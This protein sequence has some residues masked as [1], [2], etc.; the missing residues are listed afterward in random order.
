MSMTDRSVK[1]VID[2]R[3]RTA[4]DVELV[5]RSIA[6]MLREMKV[7]A[8]LAAEVLGVH[9]VTY[10]KMV[11]SRKSSVPKPL[12]VVFGSGQWTPDAEDQDQK[13]CNRCGGDN[14]CIRKGS[15]LYCAA[16]HKTGFE[17]QIEA[18]RITDIFDEAYAT[19]CDAMNKKAMAKRRKKSRR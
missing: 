4:I 6:A 8:R 11:A 3:K 18:E 12:A 17:T 1:V 15:R 19:E 5:R 9:R 14:G 10:Q 7:P 13:D 2:G 16:C